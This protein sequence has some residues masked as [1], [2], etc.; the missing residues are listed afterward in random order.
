MGEGKTN[1]EFTEF[2]Q[3]LLTFYS[4]RN[5]LQEKEKLFF[6]SLDPQVISMQIAAQE[7]AA[8]GDSTI[9]NRSSLHVANVLDSSF[10]S[11][12]ISSMETQGEGAFIS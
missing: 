2:M 6:D 12:I 11:S 3:I 7:A 4:F 8:L 1:Y 5:F 9:S 10:S